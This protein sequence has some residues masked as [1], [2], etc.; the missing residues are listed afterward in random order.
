MENL[1]YR[2]TVLFGPLLKIIFKKQRKSPYLRWFVAKHDQ[3]VHLH[4]TIKEVVNS[5]QLKFI[6]F[7]HVSAINEYRLFKRFF[8]ETFLR[9]I[10]RIMTR[11]NLQHLSNRMLIG[12]QPCLVRVQT[13]M[14][15]CD[16]VVQSWGL[17]S[18]KQ[19]TMNT[20]EYGNTTRKRN[21]FLWKNIVITGHLLTCQY[22]YIL[23][24]CKYRQK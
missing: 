3:F 15:A 17:I 12:C 16:R 1:K 18:H 5:F 6:V 14:L 9:G 24:I 11:R 21:T 7:T 19:N 4:F 23:M 10:L 13:M 22:M 8:V 20:I 2:L